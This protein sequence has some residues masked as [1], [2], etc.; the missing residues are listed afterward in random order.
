MDYFSVTVV[1]NLDHP[2]DYTPRT[3]VFT[4]RDA[5]E[6]FKNT[7]ECLFEKHGQADY[8]NVSMDSGKVDSESYLEIFEMDLSDEFTE[9]EEEEIHGTNA[10]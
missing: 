7:L 6:G 8:Y 2:C 9:E 1:S 5:A 10:S 3:A 4:N